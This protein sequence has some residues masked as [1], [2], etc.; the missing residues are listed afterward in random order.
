M[1][2]SLDPYRLTSIPD[3][4]NKWRPFYEEYEVDSRLD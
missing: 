1:K 2:E 4:N 3:A